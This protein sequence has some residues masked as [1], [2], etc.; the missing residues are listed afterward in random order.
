M[1]KWN[2]RDVQELSKVILVLGKGG[3]ETQVS[4]QTTIKPYHLY[5]A[6]KITIYQVPLSTMYQYFESMISNF[7]TTLVVSR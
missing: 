2:L 5:S 4:Q 6:P 7:L 3:I 1:K